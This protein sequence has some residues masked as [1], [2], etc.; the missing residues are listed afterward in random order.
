MQT[1]ETSRLL[2]R[3]ETHEEYIHKFKTC[4]DEV[5]MNYYGHNSEA[6]EVQKMKVA[7]GFTTY[8]TAVMFFHHELKG[9]NEVIG[10][11]SLHNWYPKL[12]RSELGYD[13][14]KEEHKNRGYMKE[15]LPYILDYG[16]NVMELNRIEAF[17]AP[18]N[19]PSKRLVENTGFQYEGLLKEHHYLDGKGIDSMAYG[20]LAK[21][22]ALLVPTAAEMK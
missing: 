1:L 18:Y 2:I 13:I 15:V 19:T 7:G 22:Y 20:L 12:R 4:D 6:L 8:R 14:R 5:L 16:F 10:S 17:I 3:V 11:T 9:S 21:D